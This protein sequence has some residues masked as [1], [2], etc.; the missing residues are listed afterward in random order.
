MTPTRSHRRGTFVLKRRFRGVRPIRRASGTTDAA[1]FA[2]LERMLEALYDQ[3]RLDLL[4]GVATGALHPLQVWNAY[5]VGQVATLPQADVLPPLKDR[6]T[7]W[8]AEA[9]TSP[10]NRRARQTALTA[11]LRHTHRDA[12]LSDLPAALAA[13][14]AEDKQHA[15][16]VNLARAAALAFVRDVLGK[17][18]A[19]YELVA[20]V[21]VVQ[22]KAARGPRPFRAGA[23]TD[24]M[25]AMGEPHGLMAWTMATTGM[26]P[27]EYWDDGFEVEADRVLVHGV[28]RSGRERIVPRV[29]FVVAPTRT[30]KHF[31]TRL[32]KVAPGRQIYDLR[33]TYAGLLVEAG[34]PANRRRLYMGHGAR[35]MTELYERPEIAAWLA[36]D[37]AALRRVLGEPEP[38]GLRLVKE[39]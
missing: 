32:V 29:S 13:Y 14:R 25:R 27:K 36:E 11:L 35:T 26:G 33:R 28:K 20:A 30:L 4:E 2:R 15:R 7:R 24:L 23:L 3:G 18:H 10:A 1:T 38:T 9:E 5:R 22:G 6:W 19:L 34:I 17:R 31:R 39:A 12:I 37:A 16:S 21:P 8:L